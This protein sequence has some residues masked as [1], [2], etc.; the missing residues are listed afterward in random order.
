MFPIVYLIGGVVHLFYLVGEVVHLVHLV[1]FVGGVVYLVPLTYLSCKRSS[2]SCSSPPGASPTL[3]EV[4]L[5][6][7]YLQSTLFKVWTLTSD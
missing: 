5:Q 2:P 6:H 3:L 7:S 1:Y 4:A